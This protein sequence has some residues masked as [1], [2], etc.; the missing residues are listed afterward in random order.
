MRRQGLGERSNTRPEIRGLIDELLASVEDSNLLGPAIALETYNI[1]GMSPREVFLE[2]NPTIYGS[3]L[4]S[5]LSQA[6]E[7][8]VAVC[9][10]GPNLE[11][12]VT[13][14]TK[15]GKPLRGLLL[16]G[17]GS[18]AV[19]ALTQE[20]CKLVAEKIVSRGHQASSPVNPGMPGLP[21]TEQW[22]LLKMVSAQKIGVS[23]T[24]SGIMIPRKSASMI[25]GIGPKMST[26]TQSEVCAKCNLSKTCPYRIRLSEE[27]K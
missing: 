27:I 5:L 2:G 13:D 15:H 8:V 20:T 24:S 6:R 4:P 9:T 16:D 1:T 26:W 21:I 18:A 19:D 23:L 7:L 17:I 3:L 10:I 14:Y 11:K 25:M 12:K 22:K